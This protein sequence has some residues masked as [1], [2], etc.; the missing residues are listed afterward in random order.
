MIAQR[1]GAEDE[2][3]QIENSEVLGGVRLPA[4]KMGVEPLI[5]LAAPADP[6]TNRPEHA[7]QSDPQSFPNLYFRLEL[8]IDATR[9]S[10]FLSSHVFGLLARFT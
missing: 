2:I 8:E 3:T 7:E 4:P 5:E 9:G 10:F 1:S 6:N